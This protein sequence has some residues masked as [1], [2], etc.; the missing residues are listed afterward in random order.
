VD[1]I[2]SDEDLEKYFENAFG[3]YAQNY[4][5]ADVH[6]EV[7]GSWANYLRRYRIHPSQQIEEGDDGLHVHLRLGLCPEF[8]TFVL[9]MIPDIRVHAPIEFVEELDDTIRLWLEQESAAR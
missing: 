4:P 2:E 5:V 6:L 7:R 8:R 9:G 3:I 1:E